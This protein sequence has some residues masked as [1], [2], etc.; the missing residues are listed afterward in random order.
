MEKAAKVKKEKTWDATH[1]TKAY[2]EHALEHGNPPVSIFAFT[3]KLG[4][5]ESDF[6]TYFNSFSALERDIWHTWMKETIE[7]VENDESYRAYSV[8]EKLLA[9]YFSWLE[10]LRE[11]RSFVQM[12]K[13]AIKKQMGM[14]DYLKSMHQAFGRYISDLMLEG[15]DTMEVAE[16][17]FSGQYDKAFWAQLIFITNFWL[18][19]DS[20]NFEQTDA[21]VEKSVN[22]AFDLIAKGALDSFLDLAKFLFQSARK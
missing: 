18:N 10:T 21:A 11:N 13:D 5:K 22:F 17:P 12:K 20:K 3:K 9:F 6:Y 4:A 19:D 15:K 7:V 1:F 16:R 14:P 8:R 2:I